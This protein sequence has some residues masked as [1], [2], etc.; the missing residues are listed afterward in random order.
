LCEP[1]HS[2]LRP[3]LPTRRSSDLG[4]L[5]QRL[6]EVEVDARDADQLGRLAAEVVDRVVGE[7]EQQQGA[8][9][10]E[11]AEAEDTVY[12][13]G[14]QAPKR[15]EEHTSELQSLTNLVFRLPL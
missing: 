4:P 15:S 3:R 2:R 11:L 6:D 5:Q 9:G 8:G 13:L 1:A 7:A 10:E 12:N 14:G